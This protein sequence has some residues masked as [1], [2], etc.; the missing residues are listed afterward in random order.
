MSKFLPV[1]ILILF[2]LC[3][4]ANHA[5]SAA[6]CRIISCMPNITEMLFAIGLD[7]RIVGVTLNCNYPPAAQKKEKV[8]RETINVEKVM[9]LQ[10]DLVVMQ[11]SEQPREIEK[12][13]KR[14][15]PVLVINP[16]TIDGVLSAIIELGRVTGNSRQAIK[17]AG[18]MQQRLQKVQVSLSR[19]RTASHEP[20]TTPHVPRVLVIVGVNPLVAVGGNNFIDDIIRTAGARNIAGKAKN[21]YPQYSFEQLVKDDPDAV[22]VIKNV[23]LG[24]KEIYND[25]RWQKLSAVRNR[26]VLVIDAD[27]ISRPGPRVVDAI[28]AVNDFL[29]EKRWRGKS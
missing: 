8:G 17:V 24:E 19:S 6:P 1:A 18:K 27:I 5:H 15:L 23:V 2:L 12:L 9:S 22:I 11:K 10:P 16:Q 13:K 20:R 25:K 29:I 14:G 7:S 4:C 26:R 28:E 3:F 21:P